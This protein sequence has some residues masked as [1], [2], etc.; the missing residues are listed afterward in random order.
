MGRDKADQQG[1]AP[2][3]SKRL[4]SKIIA[5]Y[6]ITSRGVP[7]QDDGKLPPITPEVAGQEEEG[8]EPDLT[9]IIRKYVQ[10]PTSVIKTHV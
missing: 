10:H 6:F 1:K 2:S 3:F 8:E 9:A 7:D 5:S 4:P